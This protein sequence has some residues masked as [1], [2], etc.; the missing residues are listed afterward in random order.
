[1]FK[2]WALAHADNHSPPRFKSKV[3]KVHTDPLSRMIDEA[4]KIKYSATM[5]SKSE[6]KGYRLNRIKIDR[7]S[8]EE[9]KA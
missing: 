6:V 1:M 9:K 4:V 8:W 5:N 7:T 3:L 2:H